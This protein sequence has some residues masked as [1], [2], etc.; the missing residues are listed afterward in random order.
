[1]GTPRDK[2]P[3]KRKP[4]RR[5]SKKRAVVNRKRSALVKEILAEF[6]N[7]QM[8]RRAKNHVMEKTTGQIPDAL[9]DFILGLCAGFRRSTQVHE[10]ATRARFPGSDTILDKANCV[11]TCD[12]CHRL[13]HDNVALSEACGLL[14]KSHG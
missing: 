8:F 1:M 12:G 9:A 14:V 4:L 6:P 3:K 10:P 13:V 7:C 5:V 11:A 2:P